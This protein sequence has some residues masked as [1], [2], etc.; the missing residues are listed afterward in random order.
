MDEDDALDGTNVK[1]RTSY[2]WPVLAG[3]NMMMFGCYYCYDNPAAL[4]NYFTEN[5]NSTPSTMPR[6]T[7]T[8]FN[9]LYSAYSFPNTIL[10]FFG[11]ILVDKLGCRKMILIFS[12]FLIAGQAIFAFATSINSYPIMLVGR[13]V[14]GFGGESLCVAAQT[15][16]AD[17][18]MG[19]EMGDNA[20]HN[21]ARTCPPNASPSGPSNVRVTLFLQRWRWG[22]ISP[23]PALVVL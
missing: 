23:S 4:N 15:M 21:N 22:S 11:G 1:S 12:C 2:R 8:Q 6:L 14:Y 17:W 19:Q 9:G 18:F 7:A 13:A 20:H 16:L 3:V 10:P 5:T